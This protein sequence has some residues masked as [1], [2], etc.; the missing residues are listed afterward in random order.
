MSYATVDY[1]AESFWSDYATACAMSFFWKLFK[2]WN[3]F[4]LVIP[5]CSMRAED[6]SLRAQIYI[7]VQTSGRNNQQRFIELKIWQRRSA[8]GAKAFDMPFGTEIEAFYHVFAG[9]P[10]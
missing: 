7:G 10:S 3:A 9:Q 4:Q 5:V 2:R 8:N 6:M 1:L